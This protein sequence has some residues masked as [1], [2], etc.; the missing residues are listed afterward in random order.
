[1]EKTIYADEY[2]LLLEWL[3]DQRKLKGH[4]MRDLAK[5][6]KVHHSW[7]GRIEQGERR[8]D[9]VEFARL[10][11]AIGCDAGDGLKFVIPPSKI[12]CKKPAKSRA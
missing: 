4:T 1:M 11:N 10:C 2:R 3:R 12:N 9:I 8:L 5:R 6:L 7:I